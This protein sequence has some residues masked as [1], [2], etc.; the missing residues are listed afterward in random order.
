MIACLMRHSRV[1]S[2]VEIKI[3]F[4]NAENQVWPNLSVDYNILE[5]T[6]MKSHMIFSKALVS[7]H[8]PTLV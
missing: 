5:N 2:K 7:H 4:N 8:V 6:K 1:N 3:I